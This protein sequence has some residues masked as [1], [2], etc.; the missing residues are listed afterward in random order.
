MNEVF[1]EYFGQTVYHKL[2]KGMDEWEQAYQ[3][4]SIVLREDVLKH[5]NLSQV[6]DNPEEYYS[7]WYL[8]SVEGNLKMNG[9]VMKHICMS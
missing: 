3:E 6:H 5:S 8:A 7:A 9:S 1:P 2:T 4:A